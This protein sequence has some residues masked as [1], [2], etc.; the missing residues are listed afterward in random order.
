[1]YSLPIS[2]LSNAAISL[3]TRPEAIFSPSSGVL[4]KPSADVAIMGLLDLPPELLDLIID[5]TAP[6]GIEGFV[7]SCKTVYGRAGSQIQHHNAMRQRW[8]HT[9][10]ASPEQKGDTLAILYQISRDPIIAEYIEY[11]SLWD[12]RTEDE[13]ESGDPDAYNFRDDEEAMENIKDLLRYAE[14]FANAHEQEWWDQII[15]EDRASDQ[16]NMD[17]LYATV[18]LLSLL[19]NLRELQLPD[20]WHEVRDGEAAEA[21]VSHVQSLV[22]TSNSAG[23]RQKPLAKLDTML[24]FVEEGYD[25]RVGLQCLQPFM[26][27][28]NIR[29]LYAVSCVAVDEDWGGVPFHW[30]NPKLSSPLTKLEFACCCM[31]AGGLSALLAHTPALTVFKYS[32]QTKWDGLEFDWNAGEVLETIA[33][34][35]SESLI[36]IAITIDEL[37]GEVVNGLSSFLRFRN[38]EKLEVDVE[39]FCG[40]PLESGQR[41]GREAR[42]PAGEDRWRH[43][44][45]PCMGDMLPP[46]MKELH[47]NTNFPEPSKDALRALFKNIVERRKDQLRNLNT[48]II[49]Q[50]RS[51]SAKH[52]AKAHGVAFEVFDEDVL[53]PRPRSL[54]PLWKREFNGIVGG[55][56]MAD[57]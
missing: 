5:R 56:V 6:D 46:S 25:V 51:S 42:I 15:E 7:L 1:M 52:I 17:K 2:A 49:R 27:L 14:H 47:V 28:K 26:V 29:T 32:H 44:D 19:P 18:A 21:L 9:N 16:S 23:R 24:P 31:D 30:P 8:A 34:Y 41:L 45:I 22:D 48:A 57:G 38:L 39:C 55:I 4:N 11:L 40:P 36:E 3:A 20:R 33:N 37:H 10:N 12:R 35:C 53:D 43:I 50:Y 54:M 13:M